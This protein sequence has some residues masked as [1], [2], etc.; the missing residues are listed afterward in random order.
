VKLIKK[1]QRR[2][3]ELTSF[4]SFEKESKY[5]NSLPHRQL[6]NVAAEARAI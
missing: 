5:I 4:G 6:R 2:F 1:L 3:G